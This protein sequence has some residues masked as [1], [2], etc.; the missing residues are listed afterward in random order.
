MSNPLGNDG[1]GIIVEGNHRIAMTVDQ[2]NEALARSAK[3]ERED[4]IETER[5][6]IATYANT[7]LCWKRK[8]DKECMHDACFEMLDLIEKVWK[9]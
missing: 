6:R 3:I 1:I 8:E 2:Y 7:R 4:A 5:D 9:P